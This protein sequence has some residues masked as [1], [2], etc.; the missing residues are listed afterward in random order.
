M[1][2]QCYINWYN[3]F[4]I[5]YLMRQFKRSTIRQST[6]DAHTP[7][8][9]IV[10]KL[11]H[12]RIGCTC[13]IAKPIPTLHEKKT[14]ANTTLCR[15]TNF[16][17]TTTLW[18]TIASQLNSTTYADNKLLNPSAQWKTRW[19]SKENNKNWKNH[20]RGLLKRRLNL[21]ALLMAP[22]KEPQIAITRAITSAI[23]DVRQLIY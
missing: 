23:C 15:W 9:N 4:S 3:L 10:Q 22:Y 18:S 14:V 5:T 16:K 13:G 8:L 20:A 12:Q 1:R 6:N 21:D 19:R 7:R 17:W 11:T 2:Q